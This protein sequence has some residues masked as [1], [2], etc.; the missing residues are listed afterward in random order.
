M[1]EYIPTNESRVEKILNEKE[2]LNVLEEIAGGDY[3]ILRSL[4]DEDGLYML[5]I[6]TVDENDEVLEYTYRRA[7]RY[8]ETKSDSTVI[9]AVFYSGDMP[10]GGHVIRKYKEGSWVDEVV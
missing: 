4:E 6:R 5:E 2:V 7:G 8:P 10:V 9:D 3:E 1:S